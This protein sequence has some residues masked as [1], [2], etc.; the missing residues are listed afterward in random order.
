MLSTLHLLIQW[1]LGTRTSLYSTNS[2]FDQKNQIENASDLEQIFG[3][4]TE[5]TRM[6]S[7]ALLGQRVSVSLTQTAS[8]VRRSPVYCDLI[9]YKL[10]I[11]VYSGKR[12]KNVYIQLKCDN[13]K[14]IH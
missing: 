14:S 4:R 8:G 3:T 6:R 13:L 1:Y 2:V 5:S 9:W 10:L 7:S 12:K 11:H